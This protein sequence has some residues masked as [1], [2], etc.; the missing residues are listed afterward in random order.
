MQRTTAAVNGPRREQADSV[1]ACRCGADRA[2]GPRQ[3]T[4]KAKRT[5][6]RSPA[7]RTECPAPPPRP[8]ERFSDQIRGSFLYATCP[9]PYGPW[10][11]GGPVSLSS[12]LFLHTS[13][14]ERR[15]AKNS[16]DISHMEGAAVGIT[17]NSSPT[18]REISLFLTPAHG[19]A[20]PKVEPLRERYVR[21]APRATVRGTF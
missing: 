13:T 9:Q 8:N 4:S 5:E 16:H 3:V 7:N 19:H 15:Q 17:A 11:P 18:Q 21:P 2:E 6:A 14:R 10:V 12:V 20:W 1:S